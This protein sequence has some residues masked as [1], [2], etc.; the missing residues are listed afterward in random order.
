MTT[1]VTYSAYDRED[2]FKLM[3]FIIEADDSNPLGYFES[4]SLSDIQIIT[5]T[6][7][8]TLY[9]LIFNFLNSTSDIDY[10]PFAFLKS[11]FEFDNRDNK[12]DTSTWKMEFDSFKFQVK[13][14]I[15][16]TIKYLS[17][18]FETQTVYNARA[19]VS[20]SGEELWPQNTLNA[21]SVKMPQLSSEILEQS[22]IM[23]PNLW[24]T[25]FLA[26]PKL[27][28]IKDIDLIFNSSKDGLSFNRLSY[29]FIGYKGP[30]IFLFRHYKDPAYEESGFETFSDD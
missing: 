7:A 6:Q 20:R 26:L 1:R 9:N 24:S 10:G 23:T 15:P 16:F 4:N 29:A 3:L 22:K 28:L 17:K 13:R 21:R 12:G 14:T 18:Y 5:Y 8:E 19:A 2:I 11:M 30:M 25:L 27:E